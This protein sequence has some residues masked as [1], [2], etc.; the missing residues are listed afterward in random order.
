M[1]HH[2]VKIKY[3]LENMELYHKIKYFLQNDLHLEVHPSVEEQTEVLT[4]LP[5]QPY[6]NQVVQGL[7][8]RELEIL[9][10]MTKGLPNKNI[11]QSL[12]VSEKTIKNNI[13]EIFKKLNVK[14]RTHA[15]MKFLSQKPL[16]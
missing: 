5:S 16:R 1:M 14:N 4:V 6:K 10:L 7:S 13:T 15:V 9:H 8:S 2:Y 11:A 3:S 12:F